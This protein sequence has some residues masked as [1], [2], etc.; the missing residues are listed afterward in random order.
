LVLIAR[1]DARGVS[2]FD[3]AVERAK[4][5]LEA[6][7]DWIFPEALANREEFA[8]FAQA[9]EA[10]LVANMTEFGQSPLL[11]LAELAELGTTVPRRGVSDRADQ[12][13]GRVQVG[14]CRL[15][16]CRAD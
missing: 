7:A 1:T 14:R 10:P 13:M 4:R 11:S 15:E 8:R 2:G 12:R 9:V 6:G 5:Y 3:D 16:C